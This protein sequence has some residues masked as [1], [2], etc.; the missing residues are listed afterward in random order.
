[1]TARTER[2]TGSRTPTGMRMT[3]S[4]RGSGALSP[5]LRPRPP[6]KSFFPFPFPFL[7][8]PR[9]DGPA[10]ELAGVGTEP[11]TL[12]LVFAFAPLVK[13]HALVDGY[14]LCPSFPG[15][16]EPQRRC[17]G[18]GSA[19]CALQYAANCVQSVAHNACVVPYDVE[20]SLFSEEFHDRG[21]DGS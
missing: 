7:I 5:L 6:L 19:V 3:T 8:N 2:V 20:A 12:P 21:F 9:S 10:A 1:M 16:R 14:T 4:T 15:Y 11:G 18:P 13:V 17:G